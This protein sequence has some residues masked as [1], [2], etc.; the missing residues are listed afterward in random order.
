MILVSC[1]P[2]SLIVNPV[3]GLRNLSDH[4]PVIVSWRVE[5]FTRKCWSWRLNNLLRE[6]PGIAA[7]VEKEYFYL[8]IGSASVQFGKLSKLIFVGFLLF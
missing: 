2:S 5:H 8:N 1:G 3:I 4:A 7:K 6:A